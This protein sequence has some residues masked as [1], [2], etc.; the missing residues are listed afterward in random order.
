[1]TKLI[2]R[3]A[4]LPACLATLVILALATDSAG[5]QSRTSRRTKATPVK[6]AAAKPSRPAGPTWAAPTGVPALSAAVGAALASHTRGGEWGAM[7]VS[8]T[9]GATLFSQ[10]PDDMMQPASTMKMYTSAGALD[11]FGPD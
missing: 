7:V 6:R 1:M 9:R 5:A 8:L 4:G 11:R 10:N 2:H 3:G